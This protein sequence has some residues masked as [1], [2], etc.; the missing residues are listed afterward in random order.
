LCG[1]PIEE[2]A[3]R[4][5]VP[6]SWI[7][8]L[9]GSAAFLVAVLAV[10]LIWRPSGTSTARREPAPPSRSLQADGS[11]PAPAATP[12]PPA[13]APPT[14]HRPPPPPRRPPKH[15]PPPAPAVRARPPAAGPP[16]TAPPK[17]AATLAAP[18]PAPP[19]AAPPTA[20][21][22][23]K[24]ADLQNAAAELFGLGKR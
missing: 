2:N 6:W 8:I 18:A 24:A 1:S 10:V 15:Q 3:A 14:P 20:P 21:A 5:G 22:Q 17:P 12:P 11:R 23:P 13:V 7:L 9:A 4:G 19:N 16:Q